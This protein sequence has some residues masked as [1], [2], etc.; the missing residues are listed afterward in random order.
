MLLGL[1]GSGKSYTSAH[2]ADLLGMALISEDK[3]RESL[4][5][6]PNFDKDEEAVVT[7]MMIM[8]M[9]Q[10]IALGIP[11][12]FDTGLNKVVERKNIRE[13]SRKYKA[14][15][16]LIWLQVDRETARIR[17]KITKKQ[18]AINDKIFDITLDKFQA[19]QN[20]D[21][22]VVSGKH[23]FDSQKQII[24]RKL[25]EKGL[26]TDDTLKPHV[27]MPGM[28]NLAAQAKK[29]VGRV[30]YARRNISIG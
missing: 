15:T 21:Y 28:M 19:P 29:N 22:I 18:N 7:Q 14:D 30:D 16:L 24:V 2:I 4:F 6:E 9:E 27:P 20:E 5:E 23:T 3:I 25:R 12:M 26:V 13:I 11:V 8:M 10:Y 17:T 1:P